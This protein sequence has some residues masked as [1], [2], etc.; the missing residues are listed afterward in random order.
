MSFESAIPL[1]RIAYG[2]VEGFGLGERDSAF[3]QPHGTA[4]QSVTISEDTLRRVA[5]ARLSRAVYQKLAYDQRGAVAS[6]HP[7]GS[8]LS[9]KA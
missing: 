3:S 6:E 2:G 7:V 5:R 8:L 1:N 9:V 4:K